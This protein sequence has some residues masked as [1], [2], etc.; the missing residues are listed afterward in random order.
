[1]TILKNA[2]VIDA[3]PEKVWSALASLEALEH[4]DPGVKS[5]RIVSREREGLGAIRKCELTPGGWFE[6][7][8]SGWNPRNSL[9]FELVRCT[10]P[11]RRLS[12]SYLLSPAGAGTRV[13][14]R[15]EY[16][17]KFGPIGKVMDRLI[18][19]RKWDAGIK[20]F[21]VGLKKYVEESSEGSIEG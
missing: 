15:M 21:F 10:L 19:R 7:K 1:M 5:S 6:E 11:V 4:Y 16:E 3:S 18:V 14:Q 8:V 13:E 2:I 17:L 20:G 9:S 12:H